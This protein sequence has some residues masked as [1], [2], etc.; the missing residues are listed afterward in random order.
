MNNRVI[1]LGNSIN[2]KQ[3]NI[4]DLEVESEKSTFSYYLIT[5]L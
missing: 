2:Y 4:P 3:L 5:L 1:L